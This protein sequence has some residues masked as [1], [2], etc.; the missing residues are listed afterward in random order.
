MLEIL[1]VVFILLVFIFPLK[2]FAI[3]LGAG[4]T[5]ILYRGH[6]LYNSQ[7]KEGKPLIWYSTITTFANF[8][9][10]MMMG[11]AMA[12][13]VYFFIISNDY[14]FLF[15][16]AFCGIISLRWFDYT[17]KLYRSLALKLKKNSI[18]PSFSST[19]TSFETEPVSPVFVM[20]MGLGKKTGFGLGMVP[21][22]IDSG[23]LYVKETDLFFDGIFLQHHF[24][25]STVS[26]AEKISSE[27]IKIIV[28]PEKKP[29]NA[30]ELLIILRYRFYPFKTRQARDKIF[31][32]L[33]SITN[34]ESEGRA[35][36]MAPET[37]SSY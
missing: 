12:Y 26:S 16:L 18:G 14:L 22:Y 2:S 21:I 9:L 36:A 19:K 1:I 8:F 30:D 5:Y 34:I 3:A 17:F 20:C 33:S 24:D 28:N 4:T 32:I 23:Y 13:L 15:N 35:P 27:K 37:F 7:P 25:A 31:E 11:G 6:A 10:S 29:F